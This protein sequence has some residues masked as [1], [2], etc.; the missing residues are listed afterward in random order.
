M[1]QNQLNRQL[2][3]NHIILKKLVQNDHEVAKSITKD[4]LMELLDVQAFYN[5]HFLT[6]KFVEFFPVVY[7]LL[8]RETEASFAKLKPRIRIFNRYEKE[9]PSTF[10]HDL[11]HDAPLFIY[12]CG[13]ID[14]FDRKQPKLYLV[15]TASRSD[16]LIQQSLDILDQFD[17]SREVLVLSQQS[18]LNHLLYQKIHTLSISSIIMVNAALTKSIFK[19]TFFP[20]N[21]TKI[22]HLLISAISPDENN[23]DRFQ[24]MTD[25]M[26]VSMSKAGILLS[27]QPNDLKLEGCLKLLG[28]HK[29]LIVP[30]FSP[31]RHDL[32][33]PMNAQSL[34]ESLDA[35][36]FR[37]NSK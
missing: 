10:Y 28:S 21:Q 24:S 36:L 4:N 13:D 3:I 14:L 29:T 32:I 35:M 7:D 5:E 23:L 19:S 30:F 11:G 6:I 22:K 27:D 33:L 20:C 18:P 8:R 31:V 15:S 9:Y 37:S 17:G 34:R 2:A 12:V 25:H 1:N 16:R 26:A